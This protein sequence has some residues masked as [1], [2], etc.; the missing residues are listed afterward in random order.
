VQVKGLRQDTG[1]VRQSAIERAYIVRLE[2]SVI[3]SLI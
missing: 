2:Q 3:S 1:K